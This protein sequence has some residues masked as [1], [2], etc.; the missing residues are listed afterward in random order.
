MELSDEDR[1][2]VSVERLRIRGGE[3]S[4][5]ERAQGLARECRPAGRSLGVVELDP[6]LGGGVLRSAPEGRGVQ[7]YY[8]LQL[9]EQGAELRRHRR[10]PEGRREQE[11]YPLTHE[12]LDELIEGMRRGLGQQG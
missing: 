7:R 11:P 8:E 2:G 5:A 4:I 3:G 6:R 1:L 12:Q 10:D 9:D